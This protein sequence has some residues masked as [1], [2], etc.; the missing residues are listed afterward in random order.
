[1]AM[2]KSEINGALFLTNMLPFNNAM[3]V[4]NLMGA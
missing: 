3:I 2:I 1:M 4:I